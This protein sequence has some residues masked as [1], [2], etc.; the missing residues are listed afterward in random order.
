VVPG[1]KIISKFLYGKTL[2][3]IIP[4]LFIEKLSENFT[5]LRQYYKYRLLQSCSKFLDIFLIDK[6][7]KFKYL[8]F[9]AN[10]SYKIACDFNLL[11]IQP[12]A[13]VQFC[14]PWFIF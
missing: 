7:L 3:I 12:I 13:N 4:H 5:F 6:A 1:F 14:W 11:Q 8:Y 9:L 2:K 10:L